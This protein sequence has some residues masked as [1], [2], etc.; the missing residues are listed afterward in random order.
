MLF[1]RMY[2]PLKPG[3]LVVLRVTH[4]KCPKCGRQFDVEVEGHPLVSRSGTRTMNV[5]DVFV[6]YDE[7]RLAIHPT[8]FFGYRIHCPYCGKTSKYDISLE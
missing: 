6:V 7:H 4:L 3:V 5:S 8:W 1:G 2:S